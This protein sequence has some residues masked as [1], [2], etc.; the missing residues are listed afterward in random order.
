M[1]NDDY[2]LEQATL[3]KAKTQTRR[4]EK[5]LSV[6]TT[7]TDK[8]DK[9]TF[10]EDGDN[11][12]AR[13]YRS[14]TLL[15]THIIKPKFK[16]DEVVAIAQR[17]KELGYKGFVIEDGIPVA[18]ETSKGYRNKMF[19]KSELMQKHVFI[20]KVRIQRLQDISHED[21]LAE[22][23]RKCEAPNNATPTYYVPGIYAKGLEKDRILDVFLSPFGAYRAL[24]EKISGKGIWEQNPWVIAYTYKLI[25]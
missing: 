25:D 12:I 19:V 13:V 17:Y 20:T 1:L 4:I 16:V 15:G 6:L 18:V 8:Y 7:D 9:V 5:C 11:F 14:D 23:I 21:C 2:G 3:Q 24:I 22:G 10:Y